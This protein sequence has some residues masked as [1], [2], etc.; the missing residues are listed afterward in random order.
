M[1]RHATVSLFVVGGA[2]VL[3]LFAGI[4]NSWDN[5]VYITVGRKAEQQRRGN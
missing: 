4:N 1:G 3:L 2:S 5:V